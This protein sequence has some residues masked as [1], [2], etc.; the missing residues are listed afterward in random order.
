MAELKALET[1]LQLALDLLMMPIEVETDPIEVI[2]LLQHTHLIYQSVVDSCRFL[3]SRLGNPILCH[4]FREGN[5]LA[6][7]LAKK[8]CMLDTI[9]EATI[10]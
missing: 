9:T 10:C 7:F 1:D 8:G 5:K 2:D 3:L 6:D 4:K